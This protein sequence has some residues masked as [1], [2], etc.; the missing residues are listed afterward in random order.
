[1]GSHF[2]VK[3]KSF[4]T[5]FVCI[6]CGLSIVYLTTGFSDGILET[7]LRCIVGVLFVISLS[8]GL[9]QGEKINPFLL[10]SITPLSL[11]IYT[12]RISHRYLKHLGYQCWLLGVM[13]IAAFLLILWLCTKNENT[14]NCYILNSEMEADDKNQR[15]RLILHCIIMLTLSK[16]PEVCKIIFGTSFF[17]GSTINYLLYPAIVCAWKSKSKAL[18]LIVYMMT[19]LSF[20]TSFNK[21]IFLSMG[22]VTILSYQRFA[23]KSDK[24]EKKL[25][26]WIAIVAAFMIFVAFPMKSLVQEQNDFSLNKLFTNMI[27][28][29]SGTNNYYASTIQWN[30]PA[31]LQLPYMYL[32]S[33]WNN[34]Q[35]VMET[36]AE[37]TYGLWFF[38]PLLSWLQLDSLFVGKY[39]LVSY[40]SFNTF[41]FVTVLFKD[42]GIIGSAMESAFLGYFVAKVYNKYRISNS[43][44]DIACYAMIAQAT[45]EMFFSNHFFMLSY[46]FTIIIVCW[47]YKFVFKYARR[48]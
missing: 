16:I 33:A 38:K 35:Y 9:T 19:I 2:I 48:L 40:S 14:D 17:L 4:V 45:L 8:L 12:E 11:L 3:K 32:V 31:V 21:S 1:M 30:G 37:H 15:T 20:A 44:I 42:F 29:T 26:F 23:I 24:D 41:G 6:V 25:Y 5:V 10:F 34:V 27:D 36:Q 7:V 47:I 13:N 46:P 39:E 22:I 43:P 18:L 28:Y